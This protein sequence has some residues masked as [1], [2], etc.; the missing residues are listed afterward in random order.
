MSSTTI[1]A[2]ARLILDDMGEPFQADVVVDGVTARYELPVDNIDDAGLTVLLID[3]S[4]A[5]SNLIAGTDFTMDYR[6]G[7]ITLANVPAAD[8]RIVVVGTHYSTFAPDDFAVFVNSAYDKHTANTLPKPLLDP[9]PGQ[10]GLPPVEERL[11]AI[12]AVIESLWAMATGAAQDIDIVTPDGVSIPR[13][14]RYA[15]LMQLISYWQ[16]Q[17][18]DLASAL[19][20]GIHRIEM[21]TLRRV[22]RTTNRLV[23]IFREQEYDDRTPRQRILPPIDTGGGRLITY[24][25]IWSPTIE[26]ARD[27]IVDYLSQRYL[28]KQASINENP[29]LDLDLSHWE[30]TT[31]NTGWTGPT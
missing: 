22:S 3:P 19:N 4:A 15:Q 17:Y 7:I 13:S 31:I 8:T 5:V 2:Q 30:T 24:R 6:N 12:L 25:G 14:Q 28:A 26:Y 29:S 16:Q 20:V 9:A 10:L 27:D 21:Y 1:T 18:D 23:P 11:L